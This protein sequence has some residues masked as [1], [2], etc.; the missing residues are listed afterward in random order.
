MDVVK[1]LVS[2]ITALALTFSLIGIGFL[3]CVLPLVTLGL[4]NIYA[5]DITSPFTRSQLVTVADATRDYA[6]GAHD[7]DALYRSL[8]EVNYDYASD[9]KAHDGKLER[10]FPDLDDVS[11]NATVTDAAS[12]FEGVS[13]KF[14]YDSDVISHLDDCNAV[15]V[16]AY[17]VIICALVI[18]IAGIVA[19][20]LLGKK[21][22]VGNV[23]MAS[24]IA[25]LALFA[26]LGIWAL[27][28]FNGLFSSFHAIFFPEGNW[29]FAS[30]SLL[31][32]ALPTGFWSAMALVWLIVSLLLAALCLLGGF[33]LK[34][35]RFSGFLRRKSKTSKHESD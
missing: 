33:I 28:D 19:C 9:V 20:A 32:C 11:E 13:D 2:S 29:T 10:G 14:W 18:A 8:L 22:L 3:T 15:A 24:G 30:D 26:L 35:K 31:I 21:T 1:R 25:T 16:V 6:F 27:F 17:L 12:A 7:K 5:D 23:L 34:K 4:S